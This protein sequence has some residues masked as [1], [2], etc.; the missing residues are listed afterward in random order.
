MDPASRWLAGVLLMMAMVAAGCAPADTKPPPIAY[1]GFDYPAGK[2]LEGQKGGTGFAGAW[3]M[4][5]FGVSDAND[6]VIGEG[7]LTYPGIV[8]SGN[9]LVCRTINQQGVVRDFGPLFKPAKGTRYI[10]FLIR[11][12]SLPPGFLS[13]GYPIYYGIIL[14]YGSGNE[15]FF[16]KPG[17]DHPDQYVMEMRGGALQETT[18]VEAKIGETALIV[19]RAD[20]DRGQDTYT[21][22]V[23]PGA[24]EPAKG[25]SRTYFGSGVPRLLIYT[26]GTF[27]LDEIRVTERYEDIA[28]KAA[29]SPFSF[30]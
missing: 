2:K 22:Y 28:P 27:S 26:Q 6:L 3:T 9:R 5:G 13:A 17:R 14:D 10:S 21:M 24:T 25:I 8:S 19:I 16:S 15:L 11:P 18:G 12:E 23:N 1:E 20:F 7:S 29:K 30:F 4:G